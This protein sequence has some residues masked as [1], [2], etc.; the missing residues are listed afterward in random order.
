M[1]TTS[2]GYQ[3]GSI[4]APSYE[5]VCTG[6]TGHAEVISVIYDADKVSASTLLSSFWEC[7]D[8]TQG[9]R[10]GND[11]GSQYRSA[12]FTTTAAQLAEARESKAMYEAELNKAGVKKTIT[13]EIR[14]APEYFLAE[15]YHQQYL[16][17][18]PAGYC[19]LK[20]TGVACPYVPKTKSDL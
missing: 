17:K 8:P 16:D 15:E 12:V 20:G 10:Q 7:H 18:N 2:V 9:D 11:V 4:D 14:E 6:R 13:T 19:G 1:Y 5:A 3:G